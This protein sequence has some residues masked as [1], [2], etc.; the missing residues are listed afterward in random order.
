MIRWRVFH[1]DGA[2]TFHTLVSTCYGEFE[3]IVTLTREWLSLLEREE[4]R[5]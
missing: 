4:K 2:V 1:P 3:N 5:S